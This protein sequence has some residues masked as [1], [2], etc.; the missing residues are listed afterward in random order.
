MGFLCANNASARPGIDE[1][2][3]ELL[4]MRRVL[5][6]VEQCVFMV[7]RLICDE[8]Y[9]VKRIVFPF[10]VVSEA[11]LPYIGLLVP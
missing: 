8:E 3:S 2:A 10:F 7:D 1:R 11:R 4:R 6:R 5:F 9:V